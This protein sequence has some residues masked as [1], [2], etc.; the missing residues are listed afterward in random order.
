MQHSCFLSQ[1]WRSQRGRHQAEAQ[2]IGA[3]PHGRSC[4]GSSKF[5]DLIQ[6]SPQAVRKR[7][8]FRTCSKEV[9]PPTKVAKKVGADEQ[10]PAAAALDSNGQ[11]PRASPAGAVDHLVKA[12]LFIGVYG[13]NGPKA[14]LIHLPVGNSLGDSDTELAG[15][16]AGNMSHV[17]VSKRNMATMSNKTG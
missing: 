7:H 2:G 16:D 15:G 4:I 12:M 3:S 10:E 11:G 14:V 13:N 17:V 6:A 8:L 9:E 1:E 5:G